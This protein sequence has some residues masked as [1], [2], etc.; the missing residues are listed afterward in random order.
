MIDLLICFLSLKLCIP[1]DIAPA[2]GVLS[3][4]LYHGTLFEDPSIGIH[5]CYEGRYLWETEVGQL[6]IFDNGLYQVEMV[7]VFPENT[8]AGIGWDLFIFTC[9]SLDWERVCFHD[10]SFIWDRFVIGLTDITESFI[11]HP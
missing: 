1:V 10:R 3:P 5:A 2:P 8:D 6:V 11:I 7:G 4:Q 9:Y